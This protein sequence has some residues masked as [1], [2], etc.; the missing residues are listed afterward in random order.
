MLFTEGELRAKVQFRETVTAKKA[1]QILTESRDLTS[2]NFDV[3]L[4]HSILDKELIAGAKLA[5]EERGLSVYVDWIT[6]PQLD[7]TRVSTGTASHLRRRMRQCQM[8]VYVHSENAAVSKWCPWE[9]GYFDGMRRG[10]V[11]IMPVASNIKYG[12]EGQEYLGL[13]PYLVRTSDRAN[14]LVMEANVPAFIEQAKSAILTR[15]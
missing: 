6:D 7:R 1:D 3:F 12:F 5:L 11:F 13:Y 2:S 14:V 10:N 4:S 8:L 9:L 15:K